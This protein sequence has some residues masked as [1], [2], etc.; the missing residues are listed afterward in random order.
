[1]RSIGWLVVGLALGAAGWWWFRASPPTPPTEQPTAPEDA[2]APERVEAPAVAPPQVTTEAEPSSVMLAPMR[3][4]GCSELDER[5]IGPSLADSANLLTAE[6]WDRT[7]GLLRDDGISLELRQGLSALVRGEGEALTSLRDAPD[8][9]QDGFDLAAAAGFALLIRSLS[10]EDGDVDGALA[11]LAEV[12]QGAQVWMARALVARQRGDDVGERSALTTAFRLSDDP[13]IGL[14]LASSAARDGESAR[15]LEALNGYLESFPDD[16]WA[17]AMRPL[18]ARRAGHEARMLE[19]ERD[20]VRLRHAP[21]FHRAQA[22]SVLDQVIGSLDDAARLLGAERRPALTVVIYDDA[23]SF[24]EA[25]CGPSWSGAMFDGALRL[26]GA[27][28]PRQLPVAVRHESLHAQLAHVA[29][30]APLWLHEGLAQH[31][32]GQ[33]PPELERTLSLMAR[34][35]TYVPFPS[36]E[37]SFVV[38]EDG[39]SARFAYHQSYAMIA[40]ILDR[41]GEGALQRVATFL[42]DGGDPRE[43]LTVMA[44]SRPFTGDD[45]LAWI[46]ERDE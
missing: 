30:R 26:N 20:G 3:L 21:S 44:G 16:P 6:L 9:L 22:V 38:I 4:A 23:A 35:R 45:L 31:F 1:M 7:R 2:P 15:A 18:L 8:R 10:Q 14:A 40:A 46:G 39:Q 25:T 12:D 19:L 29:P 41:E 17:T 24:R 13:A 5:P 32:Q 36:L 42:H 33:R 11:G 27:T 34:Q 43:S 37:G 28:H